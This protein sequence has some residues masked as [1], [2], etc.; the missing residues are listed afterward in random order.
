MNKEIR[1]VDETTRTVQITT[2]G[3]RWYSRPEKNPAT[4]L[5]EIMFR[6][7]VTWIASHYP[8]GPGF[9]QWVADN[10]DEGE[11]I[12]KL[13]GDRGYKVHLAVGLQNKNGEGTTI[14]WRTERFLNPTTHMEELL[15]TEEWAGLLSYNHWWFN[16]GRKFFKII[17]AEFVTWPNPEGLAEDTSWPVAA[18][19]FAGTVD[20]KLEQI[21]SKE[22]IRAAGAWYKGWKWDKGSI[23][24]VDLKTSKDIWPSHKIQCAAYA[25]S[26][27]CEW[28]FTLRLNYQRTKSRRWTV[29]VIDVLKYFRLF[30]STKNIWAEEN[31]G[32][33]PLQRDYPL[34][35][36]LGKEVEVP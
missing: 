30:M 4:R 13:A 14:D 1:I 15:T 23:G 21:A 5:D 36:T 7:S 18:F 3:E 28:A 29:D 33:E 16:E 22:E 31:E 11:K 25:I 19:Q 12:K 32:V 10:G 20:L 35:V 17:A 34:E 2:L 24:I 26:E 8:M 6:P 27:R 9:Y